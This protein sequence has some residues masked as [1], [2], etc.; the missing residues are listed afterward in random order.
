MPDIMVL[1][2]GADTGQRLKR[3]FRAADVDYWTQ[4]WLAV[5][6]VSY[7]REQ[8]G[9]LPHQLRAIWKRWVAPGTKVLEAGCG[10]GHFTVAA[11]AL[12]HRAEGLDWSAPTI[13]RLRERFPVIPW[14]VGDARRMPFSD[15][16]F[17]VVYSP[18][19]CEHFEDGPTA[20]LEE[21]HRVLRSG[22][23]AVIS[24]PC[25]NN[26]LQRRAPAIAAAEAPSGAAF[27]EYLFAPEG[28]AARIQQIGFDV[29][30]VRPYA[31]LDTLVRFGGWRMPDGL[32]AV[33]RAVSFA[34]DYLPVV[35]T[36]GSTCLWVARKR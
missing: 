18:G 15:A 11:H 1:D 9:H 13:A 26:W 3:Y 6:E 16:A 5:R 35:R 29:L 31:A 17:D 25:F 28:L 21:T 7:Q 34:L 22:G 27:H 20:V 36:W 23:V 2:H 10:L 24:S 33:N 4:R 12:G 8:A 19:V 30:H 32:N 14:H